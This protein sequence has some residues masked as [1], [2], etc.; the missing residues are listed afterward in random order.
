MNLNPDTAPPYSTH[1]VQ[2]FLTKHGFPIVLQLSYSPD[3][4]LCHFLISK[5]ENGI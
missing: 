1:V 3:L 4:A 5:N 2:Q